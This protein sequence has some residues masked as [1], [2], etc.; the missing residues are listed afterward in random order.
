MLR[1]SA[2][3]VRRSVPTR[4]A[5]WL[6]ARPERGLRL[7]GVTEPVWRDGRRLHP[8]MQ[9]VT[10]L[11]ER[12][13]ARG[14]SREPDPVADRAEMRRFARL[15]SP[16]VTDVHVVDRRI[17]GPAGEI[18]VRFYRPHDAGPT[19]PVVLFAHGGGFV[20]GD[21]DTHD[22]TCRL[23]AVESRCAVLA[24]HY[25]R[26]PEHPFP[27]AIDDLTAAYRWVL[28]HGAELGVDAGRVAV[29]GDSAGATLSAALCVE[30]KRLG[31]PQPAYQCLVYPL[32]DCRFTTPS[33]AL[34][35]EGFGLTME[36][37]TWFRAQYT[38]DEADWTDPRVSPQ[39]AEDHAGLAPALVVVAGFDPL[40]D[41]G[42]AYADALRSA[43]VEAEVW[44]YDDFV[45][46]FHAFLVVPDAWDAAVQ[47]DRRVGQA[48]G[49]R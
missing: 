1:P 30:A 45:H 31:L 19:P 26:A 33:Y 43:G 38:P 35:A 10:A 17:P 29:M 18:E 11:G 27:A 14:G 40:R 12:T 37:M 41:D 44:C 39:L 47:I 4:V 22:P 13:G 23:L 9:L 15:F 32:T 21:L 8:A 2:V 25:R 5:E 48:L 34:F 24:V 36:A 42:I 49:A 7:L 28:A 3:R 16:L 6:L 46:A 20:T